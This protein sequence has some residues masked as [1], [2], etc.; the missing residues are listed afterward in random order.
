MPKWEYQTWGTDDTFGYTGGR[1]ELVNGEDT[2]DDRPIYVALAEA[3]ND[4]W[5]LVSTIATKYRVVLVFKRPR[6]E[7]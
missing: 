4:G 2:E 5:E 7:G 6:V 1:V 3:G